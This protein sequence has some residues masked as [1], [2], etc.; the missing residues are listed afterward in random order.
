MIIDV[1]EL[2]SAE[3]AATLVDD[4]GIVPVPAADR[5]AHAPD[6]HLVAI[7][8]GSLVGRCSCWWRRAPSLDGQRP[9][10]IGHYAA[11]TR[12]AGALL[13]SRACA[14]LSAAGCTVA[15]GPMDGNTSRPYRFIVERGDEPIFFLEPNNPDDW[16]LQWCSAGFSPM[17]TYT[18]GVNDDLTVEGTSTATAIDRLTDAGISLRTFDAAHADAE[19]RRI[20]ALSLV[21]FQR[22]LLFTPPSEAEFL[23][24]NAALLPVVRSELILLAERDGEL[25]GFMF[26]LPDVL[27]ATRRARID[28]IILKTVA[29]HPAFQGIG[30]GGVLMDLVQRSARRMGYV[31]AVHALIHE[32]NVSRHIS[33]RYARTVRRYALFS[34][35]LTESTA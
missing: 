21:S 13:L 29:V 24:Q 10:V 5:Q 35:I 31:R 11:A 27:Q 9:G 25:I 7:S 2:S 26:A 17:A 16:P 4:R 28:T 34:R 23:A 14:R 12:E 32:R 1:I 33:D 30:L 8:N 22:N 3:S 20:F 19:L 18:S 15:I 6:V